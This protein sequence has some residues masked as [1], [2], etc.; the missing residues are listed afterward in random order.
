MQQM[1]YRPNTVTIN[2]HLQSGYRSHKTLYIIGGERYSRTVLGMVLGP[3]DSTQVL[4]VGYC[5]SKY[6]LISK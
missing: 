5:P 3:Y 4:C 2:D 6:T 1:T